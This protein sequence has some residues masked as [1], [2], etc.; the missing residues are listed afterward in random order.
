MAVRAE[1]GA[2]QVLDI[3]A[4]AVDSRDQIVGRGQ[5]TNPVIDG[6]PDLRLVVQDLVQHSMNRRC[7]VL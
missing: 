4:A 5:R 3:A 7:L 1:F 2:Q 6:F